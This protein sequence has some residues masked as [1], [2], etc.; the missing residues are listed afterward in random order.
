MDVS[1]S[2]QEQ[3]DFASPK[4]LEAGA[5][6]ELKS[7]VQLVHNVIFVSCQFSFDFTLLWCLKTP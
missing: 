4:K 7:R 6:F 3:G 5:L 1:L 2:D